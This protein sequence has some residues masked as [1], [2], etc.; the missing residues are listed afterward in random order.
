MPQHLQA[1]VRHLQGQRRPIQGIVG[2]VGFFENLYKKPENDR[3]DYTNCIEEFL[4]P[5]II[6]NPIVQ[7]SLLKDPEINLLDRPL[8]TN[9][10]DESLKKANMKSS[11]G[12]VV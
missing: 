5:D 9:E 4:G 2:I 1:P 7:N 8:S 3:I 10:L 11:P 12:I 6:A